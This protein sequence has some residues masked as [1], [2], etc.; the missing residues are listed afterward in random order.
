MQVAADTY[1]SPDVQ[2]IIHWS[3]SLGVNSNAQVYLLNSPLWHLYRDG[4]RSEC[5][6]AR[7]RF[8]FDGQ[9]FIDDR[10]LI[11]LRFQSVDQA[12]AWTDERFMTMQ[13]RG[14]SQDAH[15]ENGAAAVRC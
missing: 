15:M 6:I 7:S 4:R 5:R 9:F 10:L 2:A 14:W 11:S 13:T 3:D 12:F 8:G 1:L